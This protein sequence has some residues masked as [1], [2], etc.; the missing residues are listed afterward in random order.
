[1]WKRS[2]TARSWCTPNCCRPPEWSGED[3]RLATSLPAATRTGNGRQDPRGNHGPVPPRGEVLRGSGA[4]SDDSG[5]RRLDRDVGHSPQIPFRPT[6]IR[7]GDVLLVCSSEDLARRSLSMLKGGAGESK[8]DDPRLK[9]ALSRLPEPED[10]LVF[11][12]GKLQ[13]AQL[14]WTGRCHSSGRRERRQCRPSCGPAR[15]PA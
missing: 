4:G 10:S 12:D 14:R 1:M 7:S 15:T 9:E 13:F 2:W 6:V 8:F 3:Y 5:R 11:Y